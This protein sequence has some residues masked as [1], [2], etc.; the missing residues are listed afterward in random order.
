MYALFRLSADGTWYISRIYSLGWDNN[1][2]AWQ[3]EVEES[4]ADICR[5]HRDDPDKCMLVGEARWLWM[6][7]S[8]SNLA[9]V[10]P[11]EFKGAQQVTMIRV[12]RRRT[13]K[14]KANAQARF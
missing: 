11:D 2:G 3:E 13:P 7:F 5:E 14:M 6:R 12:H 10:K 1:I 4:F 9:T 8:A